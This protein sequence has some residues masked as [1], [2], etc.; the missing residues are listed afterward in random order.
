MLEEVLRCLEPGDG[1]TY[2][3]GTLGAGGYAAAVLEGAPGCRILGIDRDPEVTKRLQA[4]DERLSVAHGSFGELDKIAVSMGY[5]EVDGVVLDIG[6]SSMQ[7]D[8][9]GR[10]FS[11]RVEGPLDMRMDTT[12]G[13]TAADIVNEA[14]EKEL[15]EIFYRYGEER[16]S[17]RVAAAIVKERGNASINTTTR[18]AEIIRSV[19][20]RSSADIK[21][22][23]TRCFQALRIA[24]NEELEELD[25]GLKAAEKILKAGGRLVVVTF[26]SL[27]DRRVKEFFGLRSRNLPQPSRHLPVIKQSMEPSFYLVSRK[28]LKPSEDEVQANPRARSAKLRYGIR[29]DAPVCSMEEGE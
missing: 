18:L 20:S 27:E 14:D 23:A 11:F 10:G 25:K 28:A 15:A 8:E 12:G 17:R 9:P 22:P 4:F 7:L 2:I 5:E 26:H 13:K 6:V 3:D 1:E 29:T 21:D 24:V 16:N 19:V